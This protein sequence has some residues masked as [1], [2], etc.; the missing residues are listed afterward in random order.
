[1]VGIFGNWKSIS[2]YFAVPK[3]DT[4]ELFDGSKHS[5]ALTFAKD[6]IPPVKFF[7]SW[8]MYKLPERWL[9]DNS[10]DRYSI[11]SATP[12]LKTGTDG[13]ITL[14]FSAES[15]G[16]DKEGN[17]LPAPDGPFWLAMRAYGPGESITNG[18]YEVPPIHKLD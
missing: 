2:V 3:D 4:G 16:K 15:P 8:T 5:Y 13:S 7:W 17:W 18:S 14:Y 11:G 10:I 12:E 6:Q 1:M 9:V